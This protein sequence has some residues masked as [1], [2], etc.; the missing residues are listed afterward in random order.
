M[1]RLASASDQPQACEVVTAGAV[2]PEDVR[3]SSGLAR[4]ARGDVFWTHNDAGNDPVLY[5]ID[6]T[7]SLRDRVRVTGAS[8]VDWED[9]E[10]APCADGR[11]LL[12]ADIGDND[13]DRDSITIYQVA[14]PAAGAVESAPATALHARY[15]DGPRDAESL[16]AD[17]AGNL[18]IVTKGRRGAVALYRYPAPFRAGETV[19]L[20]RV[21]ELFPEPRHEDDM[22]TSAT[23]SPDRRWVAIRSYR[24]LY[25]YPTDALVGG[26]DVQPVTFD[27]ASLGEAQGE[28][29]V[30]GDDGTVWLSSEAENRNERPSWSR[31]RCTLPR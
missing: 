23:S 13:G 3:E 9:I 6:E 12:V 20:E 30:L 8:L 5:A 4:G 14:E 2:L 31:L 17:D 16:F 22:V 18:Y 28:S 10:S 24:T 1:T 15:P 26:A 11:C 7:G 29:V 19:T 25:I 21:R 27:L